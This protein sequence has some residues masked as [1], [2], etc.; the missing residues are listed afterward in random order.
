[1]PTSRLLP[2]LLTGMIVQ[3][4]SGLMFDPYRDVAWIAL[5]WLGNDAVT[6]LLVSADRTLAWCRGGRAMIAARARR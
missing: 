5:G 2:A 1:M 6:L 4:A 3:S